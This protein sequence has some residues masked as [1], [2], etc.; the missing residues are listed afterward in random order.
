MWAKKAKICVLKQR[1]RGKPAA[2]NSRD[3]HVDMY[4]SKC[5][6]SNE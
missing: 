5:D 4:C 2:S 1:H 6:S 3:R